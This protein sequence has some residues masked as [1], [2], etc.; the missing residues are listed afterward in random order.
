MTIEYRTKKDYA[1]ALIRDL[2]V[3]GELDAGSHVRQSELAARLNISLTPVREAL[4]QLEAEG[5]VAATAH[6]GVR[7]RSTNQA[8]L[9]NIY[10]A[11]RLL[12]PYVAARA[13][14]N[15]T[16][17]HSRAAAEML[18]KLERAHSRSDA[19]AVRR[20]NYDF[21][22]LLYDLADSQTLV[23][24]VRKLWGQYPWD[25]LTEVPGRMSASKREHERI[26][27][28]IQ[29]RNATAAGFACADHL[30]HSYMD[31]AR[32]LDG[33]ALDDPFPVEGVEFVLAPGA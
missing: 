5:L 27:E 1:L 3:E 11:R 8:T 29:T 10:I 31:I 32:Y 9:R 6:R 22:F 24:M 20:A 23:D 33:D 7:V 12:E 16:P 18:R 28:A 30:L 13:V 26:L 2:I 15:L 25:V 17:A 21:H 4:R 19:V 14:A